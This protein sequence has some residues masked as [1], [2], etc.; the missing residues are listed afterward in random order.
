M[1]ELPPSS[2]SADG[3]SRLTRR[4]LVGAAAWSVPAV[5]F[6]TASPAHATSIGTGVIA[7]DNPE[8]I[9]GSGFTAELKVNLT[10]PKGAQP[11]AFLNVKYSKPGVLDGPA[12]VSTKGLIEVTIPVTGLDV[13][14]STDITVSASGYLS[15]TITLRVTHNDGAIKLFP[16]NPFNLA[17]LPASVATNTIDTNSE[18]VT[19]PDGTVWDQYTGTWLYNS[20]V[21]T[22]TL[23]PH[24]FIWGEGLAGIT[25]GL[26]WRLDYYTPIADPK[27]PDI[28]FQTANNFEFS[29]KA[30]GGP[31]DEGTRNDGTYQT[32]HTKSAAAF[33]GQGVVP[34]I[35]KKLPNTKN[36]GKLVIVYTFPRFPKNKAQ[37]IITY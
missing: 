18:R 32:G 19:L 6:A 9:I 10:P 36:P 12:T 34:A 27:D 5:A 31:N 13:N 16:A 26:D 14:D 25:G 8:N 4:N 29:G 7:F 22:N 28:F 23:I 30:V 2:P 15:A 24:G 3:P 37:L 17:A 11:P 21:A 1:S 20:I 35:R 33:T